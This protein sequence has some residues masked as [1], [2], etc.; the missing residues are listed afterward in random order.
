MKQYEQRLVT[1]EFQSL[2]SVWLQRSSAMPAPAHELIE[3][4]LY[5]HDLSLGKDLE[6]ASAVAP[7]SSNSPSIDRSEN[8]PDDWRSSA[9]WTAIAR[10]R[11]RRRIHKIERWLAGPEPSVQLHIAAL[12]REQPVERRLRRILCKTLRPR[13][14]ALPLFLALWIVA[15][16]LLVWTSWFNS[17]TSAGSPNIVSRG[18]SFWA[19]NDQCGL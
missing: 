13:W 12:K 14:L 3:T 7:L 16:S 8:E 17:S 1:S 11:Q 19:P 2:L 6:S 9:V 4:P 15:V 18:T 10:I 5:E